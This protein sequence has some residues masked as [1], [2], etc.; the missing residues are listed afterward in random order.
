MIENVFIKYRSFLPKRKKNILFAHYNLGLGGIQTKIIELA[1]EISKRKN[2]RAIIYLDHRDK[3]DRSSLL[4][5]SVEIIYCPKIF[6]S[7]IKT[8]YYYL[9]IL[10]IFLIRPSSIFVA[11]ER[12]SIFVTKWSNI[13]KI[14]I[15]IV[16]SVDTFFK[17]A[18]NYSDELV[19]YFFN[20]SNFV[21][22]V[23]KS[24]FFDLKNRLKVKEPPLVYISNWTKNYI[25]KIPSYKERK[26]DII[27]LGRFDDV[28]QPLLIIEFV[29]LAVHKGLNPKIKLYGKGKLK[30]KIQSLIDNENLNNNIVIDK[31]L[32][33]AHSKLLTSKFIIL[34][35]KYEAISL[36]LLEAM[37]MGCVIL[38]LSSPGI[39]ELVR[40]GQT[41]ICKKSLL[42]LVDSY[43]NLNKDRKFYKFLQNNALKEQQ[44]NYSTKNLKRIV[45]ILLN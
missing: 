2:T 44:L 30:S 20:Q 6:S 14:P 1:N 24:S 13:F 4:Q 41:G 16:V 36:V 27:F 40:D 19:T 26:Q 45:N 35:S 34:T 3:F 18:Q 22:A 17:K 31:P 25:K 8:R 43:K 28:K 21:I 9:L 11:S 39:R 37:S 23:S 32:I 29:K 10:L 42:E 7:L 38:S 5:K 33:K 12:E 15:S